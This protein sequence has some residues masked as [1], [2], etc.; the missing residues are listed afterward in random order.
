MGNFMNINISNYEILNFRTS[1]FTVSNKGISRITS[2]DMVSALQELQKRREQSLSKDDINEVLRRHGL[3]AEE[4]Y[5]FLGSALSLSP[6][7]TCYFKD[8]QII[9]D[10]PGEIIPLFKEELRDNLTIQDI[11]HF[12]T[13]QL[14]DAPCFIAILLDNYNYSSLKA[15]YF[16]IAAASPGSAIVVCHRENSTFSISPPFIPE[17]GNPCYFCRIDR[18]ISYERCESS[19]DGWDKLLTFCKDDGCALPAQSLTTLQRHW[20]VGNIIRIIDSY[21]NKETEG[22]FQD[23]V[24]TGAMVQLE[25]GSFAPSTT[26][27]WGMCECLHGGPNARVQP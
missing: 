19:R 17:V 21:T 6:V 23:S 10:W 24:L 3:A 16:S 9:H 5:E 1:T 18:L 2:E 8:I 7:K 14:S 27:H 11:K 22:F 13:D 15:L 26:A 12:N 4:A 25:N 20:A